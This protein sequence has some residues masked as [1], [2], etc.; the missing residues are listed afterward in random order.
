M[1]SDDSW[2]L[3]SWGW[4]VLSSYSSVLDFESELRIGPVYESPRMSRRS[5]RLHTTTSQYGDDSLLDSALHHSAV[6]SRDNKT[7]SRRAYHSVL[8]STQIAQTPRSATPSVLQAHYSTINSCAPSDASLLSSLLDESSIQERTVVDSFWG[9]DE[10]CDIKDQTIIAHHSTVEAK[11]QTSTAQNGYLCKD[12]P[13]TS[14]SKNDS[15]LPNNPNPGHQASLTE[16]PSTDSFPKTTLYCRDNNRRHKPGVLGMLSEMC[17]YGSGRIAAF[18]VYI[19]TLLMQ[20]TLLKGL[21]LSVFH[22]FVRV[23]NGVARSTATVLKKMLKKRAT[24]GYTNRGNQK[25]YSSMSVKEVVLQKEQPKFSGILWRAT[26][27]SF[28]WLVNFF[29]KAL[30]MLSKVL[31][32]V[33]F[34]LFFALCYWGPSG[35]VAMLPA[36]N[37]MQWRDSSHLNPPIMGDSEKGQTPTDSASQKPSVLSVEAERLMHLEE[38]LSQLWDRVAGGLIRQEEQHTEV[39]SL[40]NTLRSELHRHT[41]RESL[42]QWI[43]DLLEERFSLL[44]GEVQKEAKNTRQRQEKHAEEQQ[45]ENARLAEA[46]AL[47]QKLARKTE[48]LQRKQ[49]PALQKIPEAES[50]TPDPHSEEDESGSS[51]VLLAEVRRLEEAL[52]RIR[53]DV[54]GLVGCRDKCEQLAS[55]STSVSEQ[56]EREIKSLFYG[57]DRA[58]ELELPESLL[59]WLSDH[60]VSTTEL[61]ASLSVLESSILGNLSL[62]VEEG[63]SRP[64]KETITQTVLQATGEAGLSEKDVQLIVN[65]A[66]KLYSEDR[67]GLV[68]Y[69]LE[70]GGG[71]IISTRCSESFNTKTALMSLFGVPL[72]YFS[73][74]PRVVIQPNVHPGNCWAFKGSYG[75]LVIGLSMK[76]VPTAFSLDHIP[77]SLSPTGNISSAPRDFN[78]YGL[79]EEQQEEGQL[80]GQFVYEEDGDALQTFLVSEEVTRAFQ[81]IEM[82]VLSNWGHPEYT[83]VYRF[84]VHGK[85]VDE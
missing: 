82:R 70:S 57:S 72:W 75:Y 2:D 62:Q 73:Q 38:S 69:A 54:Q 9:L 20:V 60:F 12:C 25:Y 44:K 80:L 50:P 48:E 52:E 34:L 56:V 5:L 45:S 63:K 43:G 29:A 8:G 67:T 19:C 66:M 33:P 21:L 30:P 35:L 40:Y 85:L 14:P 47:L 24:N 79:D 26:S 77:K 61:Q 36:V 78:V 27:G 83:C 64:S 23:C 55:F 46:E 81:I 51:E 15:F 39:L 32:L 4:T 6:Y 74:S 42:G 10:D 71:S 3:E 16:K 84:R 31:F 58:A 68:D 17:L 13:I 53:D 18:V 1:T 59:Q 11:T 49:E 22:W 41:D 7:L 28:F 37:V 76:I 65:N